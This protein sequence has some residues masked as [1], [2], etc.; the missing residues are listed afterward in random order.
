MRLPLVF[1]IL[2]WSLT[3][4]C[5][6]SAGAA[7]LALEDQIAKAV[8]SIRAE[9][10]LPKLSRIKYRDDLQAWTCVAAER[11]TSL[12]PRIF[13]TDEPLSSP[14]LREAALALGKP[15]GGDPALARFAVAVWPARSST[16]GSSK[17]VFWVG[18]N[19]YPT[20]WMEFFLYTFTD[21]A[22]SKNDWKKTVSA[23]CMNAR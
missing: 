11:D 2:A 15:I 20:A 22:F 18:V 9:A 17:E 6:L 10:H 14:H 12:N 16:A 4:H 21:D 5:Y 13:K 23:T 19:G 7:N 3:L 8:L 1:R